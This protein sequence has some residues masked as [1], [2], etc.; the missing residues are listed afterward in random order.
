MSRAVCVPMYRTLMTTVVHVINGERS[1]RQ[2][3]D[4][5]APEKRPL[6]R[7]ELV[8]RG[9]NERAVEQRLLRD[10]NSL[11]VYRICRFSFVVADCNS[12]GRVVARAS[13]ALACRGRTASSGRLP[14]TWTNGLP[15]PALARSLPGRALPR[16]F[17][18][19][20]HRPTMTRVIYRPQGV[21]KNLAHFL[22]SL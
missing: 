14:H 12:N 15:T 2:P 4:A 10:D 3:A 21:P 5:C 8:C 6:K 20:R 19:T 13:R 22:R 7:P 17:A 1:R 18:A 11:S 9:F 16:P